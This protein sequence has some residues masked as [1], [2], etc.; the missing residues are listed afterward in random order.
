MTNRIQAV[1]KCSLHLFLCIFKEAIASKCLEGLSLMPLL[2]LETNTAWKS[3][4][5][6]FHLGKRKYELIDSSHP[7]SQIT[8]TQYILT[9]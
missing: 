6:A 7:S 3:E 9:K 8:Q 5:S 1:G 4:I 2:I